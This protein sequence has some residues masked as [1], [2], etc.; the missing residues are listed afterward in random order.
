MLK[1]LL[2]NNLARRLSECFS[3]ELLRAADDNM[4]KAKNRGRN[5]TVA[6]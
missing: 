2:F 4:Y 3:D 5:R 1:T 6:L